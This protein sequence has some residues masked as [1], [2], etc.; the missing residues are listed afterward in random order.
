[1]NFFTELKD[2]AVE[3]GKK[4]LS[5]KQE[6][7]NNATASDENKRQLQPQRGGPN[8]GRGK[9]GEGGKSRTRPGGAEE[10]GNDNKRG[11]SQMSDLP[12][13]NE[14]LLETEVKAD[15]CQN[16]GY[17]KVKY[18]GSQAF[19]QKYLDNYENGVITDK[20]LMEVI[21]KLDPFKTV[22]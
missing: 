12:T 10:T 14:E 18:I 9:N 15:K 5:S 4:Y 20:I 7:A 11:G 6:E 13:A 2:K 21:L 8:G 1:M 22:S 3:I 19:E 17:E 16:V